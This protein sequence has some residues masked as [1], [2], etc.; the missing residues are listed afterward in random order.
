MINP[1]S[2]WKFLWFWRS[3]CLY[4]LI[5]LV[6]IDKETTNINEN[7]AQLTFHPNFSIK[8]NNFTQDKAKMASFWK[9]GDPW[10]MIQMQ[11]F[12]QN[13]ENFIEN[14]TFKNTIA[15]SKLLFWKFQFFVRIPWSFWNFIRIWYFWIKDIMIISNFCQDSEIFIERCRNNINFLS[16]SKW[17][18]YS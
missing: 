5:S 17:L 4:Q 14:F 7:S 2:T 1:K 12:D 15:I 11:N 9:P 16:K 6:G 10:S 8:F 18:S 13:C 3:S